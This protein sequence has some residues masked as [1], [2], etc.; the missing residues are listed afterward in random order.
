MGHFYDMATQAADDIISVRHPH[1]MQRTHNSQQRGKTPIIVGGSGFYLRWFMF[2]MPSTP[3]ASPDVVRRA[4]QALTD[5]LTAAE[6]AAGRTLTQPE[7]WEAGAQLVVDLGDPITAQKLLE[8]PNNWYRMRRVLQ[9]LLESGKARTE[10]D[11]KLSSSLRYDVRAYFLF[12]PRMELYRR[13]DQRC[14]QILL[15]GIVQVCLV[16]PGPSVTHCTNRSAAVCW[17]GASCQTAVP[18]RAPSA[19]GR[20]CGTCTIAPRTPRSSTSRP[21]C[22]GAH[23]L[24]CVSHVTTHSSVASRT[25]K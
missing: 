22:D 2:G 12:R 7:A 15:N 1:V 23:A 6:A 17:R 4:D 18:P 25:C 8:Q 3:P 13:I 10:Q 11:I 24:Q 21:W 19:T 20:C 14:E 5:A 9:I 16:V